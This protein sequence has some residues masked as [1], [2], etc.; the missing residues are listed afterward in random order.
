MFSKENVL[1]VIP[2]NRNIHT[3]YVINT[4]TLFTWK[5]L[6]DVSA[7]LRLYFSGCCSPEYD[8]FLHYQEYH[9]HKTVLVLERVSINFDGNFK[10]KFTIVYIL[11]FR[12]VRNSRL[13]QCFI[14]PHIHKYKNTK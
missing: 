1:D 7:G 12:N 2:E 13:L 8:C 11:Q 6:T 10:W 5:F 14:T 9:V 4:F 3:K